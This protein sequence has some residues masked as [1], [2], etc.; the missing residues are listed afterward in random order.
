[1]TSR[2]ARRIGGFELG[3]DPLG[4][5]HALLLGVGQV[6]AQDDELVAPETGDRVV[7]SDDRLEAGRHLDEHLVAGGVARGVVDGLE[8]VEV[9]EDHGGPRGAPAHGLERVLEP[10]EEERPV[11]QPRQRVVQSLMGERLLGLD[12][13]ADVPRD[14]VGPH[15]AAVLVDERELRRRDPA[16]VPVAPALGFDDADLGLARLDDA[17]LALEELLGRVV[18]EEVEV[19]L[20][21]DVLD[22]P[23]G[24]HAL[25]AVRAHEDEA[26]FAVLEV[27]PLL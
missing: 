25:G 2:P 10:V 22:A 5:G 7:R 6:L 27:D 23:A 18:V 21:H 15:D 16:H 14:A 24:R 19:G 17:R 11:R 4:D 9:E 20:A 12:L 13:A 8:V 26:A 3:G 1:M